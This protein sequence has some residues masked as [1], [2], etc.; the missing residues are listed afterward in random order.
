[1]TLQT[2]GAISLNEIHVEV[3]GTSGTQCSL[4]DSDIRGIGAPNSTYAD[5]LH[6]T[7]INTTSGSAI[8]IYEFYGA[9]DLLAMSTTNYARNTGT[10]NAAFSF[11]STTSGIAS[12]NAYLEC[13]L[14]RADPYVYLEVRERSSAQTSYWYTSAG[15]QTALSTTYVTL[16]RFDLTGIT[17]IRL[18]WTTPTSST[19]GSG[20]QTGS[21]YIAGETNGPG[22]TYNASS[23]SWVTVSNN[24]SIAFAFTA[25]GFAE[26][27]ASVDQECTTDIT[28]Y[29]RKSGYQ[30]TSLGTY[31]FTSEAIAI[32]NNCF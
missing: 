17:Q 18:D 6:G 1:M 31:Q 11:R 12:S 27:Y 29:A 8:S 4:D 26:C 16:G 13:R 5:A 25:N 21:C 2:S 23:G 3:G 20:L 9:A 28:A 22:A 14:R 24:Q 19:T 30:D 32:S 7:G 15:T 10:A